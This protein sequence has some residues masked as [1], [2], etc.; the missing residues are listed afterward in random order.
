M[1][2]DFN[3]YDI[4]L[5]AF[6]IAVVAV[7]QF[8]RGRKLNLILIEYTAR[9]F[10]NIL[11]PRD[12]EYQWIGLYVGYKARFL[13]PYKSLAKIEA[14]VTLMPR[15]SLFYLPIAFLTSRFDR[16]FMFFRYN[17]R[18]VSE[19]HIVRKHYY[20]LGPQRVIRGIERMA[21]ED[22]EI[23]GKTYHL[24]YNDSGLARML[25]NIVKD[26]SNPHII[27]HIAIVPSNNS[28]YVAAKITPDT[29]EELLRKMYRLARDLA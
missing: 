24:I 27:N 1:D 25:V 20:R 28:L 11:K 8:F 4:F 5:I 29:F 12:K 10:E 2:L 13:T 22:I 17:K 19:A 21:F 18:F 7:L 15:H 14:V 9:A 23:K 26:L 6:V 3:T 16:L